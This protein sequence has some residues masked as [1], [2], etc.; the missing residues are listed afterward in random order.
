MICMLRLRRDM[1]LWPDGRDK[2]CTLS[3]DDGTV[4]DRRICE[5]LRSHNLRAT[6]NIN[7]SMQNVVGCPDVV[8]S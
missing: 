2:C 5:M 1:M 3:F 8:N 6:F 4:E 7:G